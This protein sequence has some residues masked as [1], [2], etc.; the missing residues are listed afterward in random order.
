M[1]ISA[2]ALRDPSPTVARAVDPGQ[3]AVLL[4][5]LLHHDRP[6]VQALARRWLNCPGVLYQLAPDVLAQ[7]LQSDTAIATYL[8]PRLANEGPALLGPQRLLHLSRTA[9]PPARDA[10]RRW[11]LR[12]R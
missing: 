9:L 3:L 4:P 5:F 11:A 10:A 6:E 12:L 8:A 2:E 7:W 1:G